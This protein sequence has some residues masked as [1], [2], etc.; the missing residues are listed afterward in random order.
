MP[1]PP[2][3]ATSVQRTDMYVITAELPGVKKDNIHVDVEGSTLTLSVRRVAE[4]PKS[5]EPSGGDAAVGEG[6]M[7]DEASS[8]IG[9]AP[10]F[11]R[12]ARQDGPIF[13]ARSIQLPSS[14][15]ADEVA[16]SYVDGVLTLSV[17]KKAEA[18]RRKI[19]ID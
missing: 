12:Q 6:T 1:T 15:A 8:T 18:Q 9:G 7:A 19:N 13:A 4:K 10:G 11:E 5:Q 3:P 2:N 16:A 17:P 14:A